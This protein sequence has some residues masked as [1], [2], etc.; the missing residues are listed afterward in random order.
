MT[1]GTI[2]IALASYVVFVAAASWVFATGRREAQVV[3]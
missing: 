1:K 2:P 3:G